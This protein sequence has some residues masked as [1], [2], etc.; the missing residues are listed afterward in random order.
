MSN[1]E[2]TPDEVIFD[3]EDMIGLESRAVAESLLAQ[4]NAFFPTATPGVPMKNLVIELVEAIDVWI[5]A[6][7]ALDSAAKR[8]PW[9]A[10]EW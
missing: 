5:S 1:D 7:A 2:P 4:L 8:L 3:L 10:P 9:S 6:D